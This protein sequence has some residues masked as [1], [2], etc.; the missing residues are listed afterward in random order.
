MNEMNQ[1]L[2]QTF[3]FQLADLR[4]N[5]GGRLSPRQ[6]ARL[7]AASAN[8][9]LAMSVFIVVM[10]GTLALIGWMSWQSDAA[11]GM[12]S[13]ESLPGLIAVGAVVVVVIVI[14]WLTSRKHMSAVRSKQ[15]G[16]AKG[17]MQV[18][19]I[20]PEEARFEIKIG[21][22]K[23]R[24]LTQEQLQAF[25]PGVEYRV[26]YLPG[27]APTILSAEVVGSEWPEEAETIEETGAPDGVVQMQQRARLILI[28]L[29]VLVLGIPIVAFAA[30]TSEGGMRGEVWVALLVV[31]VGFVVWAVGRLSDR[32]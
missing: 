19:K 22:T 16:V 13:Q 10:L 30:S 2:Q 20:R 6:Q 24:L 3:L 17:E 9:R 1:L 4:A 14:G 25:Q 31:A 26:Y 32:R 12:R 23:L 11:F 5:Q 18:G 29:G 8:M 27:P 21:A 28:V 15:I 7:R